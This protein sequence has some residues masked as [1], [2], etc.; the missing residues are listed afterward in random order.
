MHD[1]VTQIRDEVSL[2][3]EVLVNMKIPFSP[4]ADWQSYEATAILSDT[5]YEGRGYV[6]PCW[7]NQTLIC[8]LLYL[9]WI[10]MICFT[11][12][13]YVSLDTRSFHLFFIHF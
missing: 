12:R 4:D 3:L 13:P 8:F 6:L 5:P 9:N 2:Q 7:S 10:A 1:N 11:A